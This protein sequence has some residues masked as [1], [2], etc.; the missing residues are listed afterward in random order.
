MAKETQLIRT[1]SEPSIPLDEMSVP[2][3]DH[4][5]STQDNTS[6]NDSHLKYSKMS[7]SLY[8]LVKINDT[9]FGGNDIIGMEISSD[10]FLPTINL[11]I[12][13]KSK[14][15]YST[16]FP[17]DG[18]VVSIFIRSNDDSIKPV[19]N[20]YDITSVNVNSSGSET[21]ADT[22]YVSGILRVPGLKAMK[23]FSKRGSSSSALQSTA[24]DL[25]LGFATNEPTTNDEQAWICPYNTVQDFCEEVTLSSWKDSES[26]FTSFID[27]FYYLNHVNV[28]PLFS[29]KAD[30]DDAVGIELFS[31]DYAVDSERFK[32]ARK[33]VLSNW[34]N[35]KQTNFYIEKYEQKNNS[36]KVGLVDGYKRYLH[37]YDGLLREK[38]TIFADPK[39]TP[40]AEKDSIILKG[41]AN[42]NFYLDQVSHRWMGNV[43][44]NDGENSHEK[45]LYAKV[46]NHQNMRHSKKFSLKVV[47]T[48]INMNIRRFQAIPVVIVIVKDL[49]RKKA[50]EPVEDS[51]AD[52]GKSAGDQEHMPFTVD[53]FYSGFYVVDSVKYKYENFRFT[54]EMNLIRREWPNPATL[55][56]T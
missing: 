48:G 24:E 30:I 41:R 20:D 40:G 52:E 11:R 42:E 3:I 12:Q 22:M 43:Y 51:G 10:G 45:L 49:L 55:L 2:D 14:F 28:D 38:Q 36:T 44:G 37:Y 5:D 34:D 32:S 1:I 6:G 16:G 8:P 4:V 18:D 47:T 25:G 21:N 53:K 26:Y 19:R 17:K 50:N 46:W 13:M 23:C 56:L 54:Q 39:V 33:H 31:Q 7:G 15:F 9:I 27:I 35:V 29:E